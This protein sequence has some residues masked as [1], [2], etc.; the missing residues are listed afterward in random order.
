MRWLF[1]IIGIGCLAWSISMAPGMSESDAQHQLDLAR[2]SGGAQERIDRLAAEANAASG[3]ALLNA[4]GLGSLIAFGLMSWPR[5]KTP[6]QP[7]SD[8]AGGA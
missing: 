1:L 6:A 4:V 7:Q 2:A 3:R 5:K 8:Q